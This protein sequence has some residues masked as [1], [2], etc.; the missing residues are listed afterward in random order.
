MFTITDLK[1]YSYCPRILYYYTC[2]PDIRPV[3]YT[4]Q[5][6][7]DSHEKERSR[8]NRRSLAMYAGLEGQRR[9][10]ISLHAPKLGLTGRLDEAIDTGQ[11]LIP[12]DYK[13]ARRAGDHFKLQIAAYALLIEEALGLQVPY[14]F[15]YLIPLRQTQKI[16]ISPA[17]RKKVQQALV[18]MEQI[19]RT[20]QMPPPPEAIQKCATCEFR[21]F[22]NDV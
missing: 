21:R 19:A 18:T 5:K 6:G 4:M 20:E 22:C 13:Q 11:T 15:L 8:A 12:V 17:L 1:Q 10:D 3:T 2:L 16:I 14:G 7:I 9:F